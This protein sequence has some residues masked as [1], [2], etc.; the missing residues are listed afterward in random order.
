MTSGKSL[1]TSGL[2]KVGKMTDQSATKCLQ[3]S[4]ECEHCEIMHTY[5]HCYDKNDFCA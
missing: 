2:E 3:F 4:I 5:C 1:V